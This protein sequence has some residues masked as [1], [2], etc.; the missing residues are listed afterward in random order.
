MGIGSPPLY[1]LSIAHLDTITARGQNAIY[2]SIFTLFSILGP[3]LWYMAGKPFLK[4]YV[5]LKQVSVDYFVTL[6]SSC[7][8][9]LSNI[10]FLEI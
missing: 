6:L 2:I 3:C 1:N 7:L 8:D 10:I 9:L 5:D 4:I